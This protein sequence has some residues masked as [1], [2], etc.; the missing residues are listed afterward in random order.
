M[1]SFLAMP[2]PIGPSHRDIVAPMRE[3]DGGGEQVQ[4]ST[5]SLCQAVSTALNLVSTAN[6]SWRVT[7]QMVYSIGT[8]WWDCCS[9]W[10]VPVLIVRGMSNQ[11]SLLSQG[12]VTNNRGQPR[13]IVKLDL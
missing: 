10:T 8:G 13:Y 1:S 3:G 2:L 6:P 9:Q 12:C 5:P 4:I 7:G 11:G